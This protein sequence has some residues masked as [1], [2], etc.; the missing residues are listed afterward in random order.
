MYSTCYLSQIL[1][2]LEFLKHILEQF[3]IQWNFMKICQVEA[4]LF[5]ADRIQLI[6]TFHNTAHTPKFIKVFIWLTYV[7]KIQSRISHW[8]VS[9]ERGC[10]TKALF[11][12]TEINIL[13]TFLCMLYL[14]YY[15]FV[16]ILY[17]DVCMPSVYSWK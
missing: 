13:F 6:V 15:D 14:K 7:N 2:N 9:T 11:K 12:H 1:I 3:S 16:L 4:E 17:T 5:H 10:I 8:L